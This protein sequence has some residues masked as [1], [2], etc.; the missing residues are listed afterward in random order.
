MFEEI[1]RKIGEII[2]EKEEKF[3]KVPSSDINK[4]IDINKE[5]NEMEIPIVTNYD[6]NEEEDEI[7]KLPELDEILKSI[8]KKDEEEDE[9]GK[10]E[11]KDS[12]LS[13]LDKILNFTNDNN[14]NEDK[15]DKENDKDNNKT[16]A[17]HQKKIASVKYSSFIEYLEKSI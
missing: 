14:E 13:Q 7:S 16:S 11:D 4:D 15:D 2:D 8:N 3:K 9:E 10:E 1:L 17:T 5:E 12:T 6:E